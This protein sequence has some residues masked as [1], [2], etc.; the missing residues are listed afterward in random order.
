MCY[1][2]VCPNEG[3][4]GECDLS[5]RRCPEQ[6]ETCECGCEL[7]QLQEDG[8]YHCLNCWKVIS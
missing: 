2:G 8:K 7:M 3:V 5:K 6:M 1:T 4:N